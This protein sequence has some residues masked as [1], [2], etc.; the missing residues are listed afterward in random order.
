M[1]TRLRRLTRGY[2][3]DRRNRVSSLDNMLEEEKP[4][5]AA[6]NRFKSGDHFHFTGEN[7]SG[8]FPRK[9]AWTEPTDMCNGDTK[10]TEDWMRDWQV[11][12][13]TI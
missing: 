6:L 10:L 5:S 7:N 9:R 4:T 13:K 1:A 3:R 8:P 2:T 11:G 12:L